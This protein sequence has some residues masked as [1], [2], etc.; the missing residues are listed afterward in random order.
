[1]GVIFEIAR[2][3]GARVTVYAIVA[4]A[5]VT[6]GYEW[7]GTERLF[8]RAHRPVAEIEDFQAIADLVA[9]GE[10]IV[11]YRNPYRVER[12]GGYAFRNVVPPQLA[13]YVDRRVTVEREPVKIGELA[14]NHPVFVIP[15]RDAAASR[16]MFDELIGSY[17]LTVL[18]W[19]AVV[20]L[21]QPRA[22]VE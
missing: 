19:H 21:N 1:L 4:I 16:E 12:R 2:W 8:A 9:P 6:A 3:S 15:T 10:R 22:A 7:Q 20:H 18:N 13:W 14:V 17:Q 11:M 5:L